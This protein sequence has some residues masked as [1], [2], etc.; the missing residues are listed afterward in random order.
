MGV[1]RH[2]PS[3]L[4]RRITVERVTITEDAFGGSVESWAE[5]GTFAASRHDVSD[6]ETWRAAEVAASIS[7]RFQ[8]R[9]STAT[10]SI[11]PVDRIVHEGKTYNITGVRETEGRRQ[12]LEI[13]A[14]A[15][16]E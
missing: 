2:T 13:S 1:K 14:V 6:A 8:V 3:R 16:A 15:R 10:A 9:W 5:L 11:T 12:G 4:D 7:V